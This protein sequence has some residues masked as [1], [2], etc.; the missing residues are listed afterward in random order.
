MGDVVHALPVLTALRDHWPKAEIC[1]VINRSLRALVEGHPAVDRVIEF[2]RGKMRANTG[3]LR[4]LRPFLSLLREPRFDLTIDL[5]G[6]LRSGLMAAATGA[7]VR[8]G[9]ASAREGSRWLYTHKVTPASERPHAVD[10]MLAVAAA[11]GAEVSKPR[12]GV[13]ISPADRL[14]AREALSGVGRPTLA[15]NLGARWVTKRWPVGSF[16]E[17]A[18]RAF[19][20]HGAG[21]VLVGA[22]EDRSLAQVFRERMGEVPVVDL[23]GATSLTQL[24]AVAEHCDLFLSND[25]GPLHLAAA[26][27]A[28]VV[29]IYTCTRPEWTG[30]YGPRSAVVSTHVIC[31]G[32]C[33]KQCGHFSCMSELGPERVWKVVDRELRR[34]TLRLTAA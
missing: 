7:Q 17:I 6:L 1:W 22:P 15:V 11:L 13:P 29:G 19:R 34:A 14:A 8:V 30:P 10:R 18:L 21:L 25:T 16:A 31:A 32:S 28:N 12:F 4:E 27:G 23:C 3:G 2:D 5:Q 26:V 9:L 33:V 20:V 24:A